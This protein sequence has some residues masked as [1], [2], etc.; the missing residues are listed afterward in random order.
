[1]QLARALKMR[2]Y[3]AKIQYHLVQEGPQK[4]LNTAAKIVEYMQGAF[5][6]APM[7]EMFYVVCL[8]RKNR[9]LGR[10]RVTVGTVN[11]TLAH[12]REVYRAAILATASAIVCVHNHP[13][14][15]PAPSAADMQ[16]TQLLRK[17]SETVDIPFLD[18]VVIGTVDDDP[19]TKG[20]F[21]FREAG[22]L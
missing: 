4:V 21:S 8:N 14:G 3:E 11:A 17:A 16:L 10:H 5:D 18:H 9:P 7:A 15:D 13:S 19:L 1:M 6:E 22:L 12:P 20:Y 2:V